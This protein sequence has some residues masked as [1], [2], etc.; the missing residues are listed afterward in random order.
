[1]R[2]APEEGWAEWQA[3]VRACEGAGD[4]SS[5]SSLKSVHLT[6]PPGSGVIRLYAVATKTNCC[7][8]IEHLYSAAT[9]NL[10]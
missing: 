2:I 3:R 6:I 8:C 10:L 4:T 9:C 1:V 7:P 5:S